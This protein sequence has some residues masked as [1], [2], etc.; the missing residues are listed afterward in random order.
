MSESLLLVKILVLTTVSFMTAMAITPAFTHFLFKHKLGKTIRDTGETP[1]FSKMHQAKSGT[2]TMGGVIIWLTTLIIALIFLVISYIFPNSAVSSLNFLTRSQT[3]LPL[4]VFIAS[5]LVGLIDDLFNVWKRGP[6][7]GGI[8]FRYKF[9]IYSGIAIVGAWWFYSKLGWNIVHVPFWGNLELGF[10]FI[11]FFIF[12]VVATAF[13]VNQTD[14]LD[15]LAAGTSL[16]MLGTLGV[17]A[18]AQGRADLTAFTGVII[19]ALLAFL[20]F[21]IYPARFFMG[22]TGAI[23]L[24][25]TIAI[26]SVFLHVAFLI[27]IIGFVFFWEGLTTI[28][29]ILS[30]KLRNGKKVF[31]SAPYHHHLEA[32]GWPEPKIVMRIWVISGVFSVFGIIIYLLDTTYVV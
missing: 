25:V 17:I 26:L 10:W 13:S 3:L 31:L 29:Q 27:P 14:G 19:G 6:N 21:N 4:G 5:A 24:G 32:L 28:I 15:G 9:I 8:R 20:W 11:P 12:V 30:K 2:P 1:I 16:V 18:F 22:D 7:G 23:S